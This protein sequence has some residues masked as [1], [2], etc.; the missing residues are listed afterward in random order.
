MIQN[1]DFFDSLKSIR[2][3]VVIGHSLS[4]IDKPYFARVLQKV[5]KYAQWFISAYSDSDKVN[6]KDFI[7]NINAG[8]EIFRSTII[9][10]NRKDSLINN[11]T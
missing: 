7:E 10:I 4:D 3:I 9:P 6:A 11:K 8:Q 2:Y 5:N 1:S